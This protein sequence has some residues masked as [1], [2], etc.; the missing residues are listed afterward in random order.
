VPELFGPISTVLPITLSFLFRFWPVKYR[1]EALDM[2]YPMVRGRSAQSSF[3][4][5][6]CLS[7]TWSTLVKLGQ[8]WSNLPKLQE[9]CSGPHFE[10]LLM[11]WAPVRSI[12]FGLGCL[13]LRV[14]AREN[15]GGKNRVMTAWRSNFVV[16]RT[17]LRHFEFLCI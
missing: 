16:S 6:Q 13:V 1:I 2:L 7:Q 4:S 15:P 3:W 17:S 10:V 8:S 9:M 12:R 11:R 14:D 5:C